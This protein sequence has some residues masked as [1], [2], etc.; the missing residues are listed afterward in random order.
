ME[1]PANWGSYVDEPLTAKEMEL[2]R[3][4]VNRQ[5]PYGQADWRVTISQELGLESTLR[6][7]G[8]PKKDVA[9]TKK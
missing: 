9:S 2:V 8:R 5:S 6:P 4:S 3:E 7:K 1:L